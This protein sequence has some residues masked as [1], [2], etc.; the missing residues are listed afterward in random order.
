TR[1]LIKKA[2][3]IINSNIHKKHKVPIIIASVHWPIIKPEN[4]LFVVC[5]ISNILSAISHLRY[6]YITFFS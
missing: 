3:C 4:T 6:A 5:P 1:T 2:Y